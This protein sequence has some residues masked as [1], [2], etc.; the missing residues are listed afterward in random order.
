MTTF[1]AIPQ[2][3]GDIGA[4]LAKQNLTA[5]PDP[6]TPPAPVYGAYGASN[7]GVYVPM[8]FINIPSASAEAEMDNVFGVGSYIRLQRNATAMK[9]SLRFTQKL[10]G[11]ALMA[12]AIRNAQ[13]Q[14][15]YYAMLAGNSIIARSV[16]GA[17]VESLEINIPF[18]S[19][20]VT[21]TVG[22]QALYAGPADPVA[23]AL[24]AMTYGNQ[25]LPVYYGYNAAVLFNGDDYT[26]YIKS[27]RISI[28]HEIER[29]PTKRQTY[30]LP[31]G[32]TLVLVS[33]HLK[34]KSQ[35]VDV[36]FELFQNLPNQNVSALCRTNPVVQINLTDSCHGA[37]GM[38]IG[39]TDVSF[40]TDKLN[41]GEATSLL[42]FSAEANAGT[43]I[44]TETAAS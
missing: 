17:K 5:N 29:L 6:T 40:A 22:M 41:E 16:V 32:P 12:A 39:L 43:F 23:S 10:R 42:S 27:V 9:P 11:I 37:R 4:F 25:A 28:K 19:G 38:G 36:S 34:E 31:G 13:G 18:E 7:L 1:V 15:D 3:G 20:A 2:F 44:L 33:R 24:P 30:S 26:D 8:D 14:L 35:M 21:A